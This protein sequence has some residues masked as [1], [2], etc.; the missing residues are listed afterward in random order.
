MPFRRSFRAGVNMV[1]GVIKGVGECFATTG[2]SRC[3]H[4]IKFVRAIGEE[5]PRIADA[6]AKAMIDFINGMAQGYS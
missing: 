1:L 2:R 3:E 6:G 5:T 4:G